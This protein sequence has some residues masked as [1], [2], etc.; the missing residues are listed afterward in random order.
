MERQKNTLAILTLVGS[1]LILLNIILIAMNGG[2]IMLSSSAQPID[3]L[4]SNSAPSWFRVALGIRDYAGGTALALGAVLAAVILYLAMSLYLSYRNAKISSLL[5]ILLSAVAL[6]YG[7]GFIIG[8]ALA[9]I[10]AALMY[11]APKKFNQT[12]MGK[13]LSSMRASS[14]VFQHFM[15]DS[16]VKDGA[17]VVLFANL[18]S[19]I[20]NGIYA[21][22]AT[23]IKTA[24][25][26]D[27]AF[28]ILLGGRLELDSSIVQTPI[29]LMGLGILKW[30][31]LSLILWLVGVNL[32]GQ[33]ASLASVA[34]LAGF[35]YA[36]VALQIFTPFV[37]A[38]SPYLA[39]WSLLVFLVTN[40]WLLLIL[41]VGMRHVMNVSL[42]KSAATVVSC[43]AIYTL[44]NYLILSQ[45][46]IPNF[47][48]YQFQSS[49]TMLFL[50]S[51][52]IA[53]PLLFMGK[54]TSG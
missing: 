16:S 33:K 47:I 49:N 6:L 54:K 9:F 53:V 34:A 36:P 10:G 37:F 32:F 1:I 28:Q 44:I 29:I 40:L 21:F 18:L 17:M 3:N 19:G 11:E 30:L 46:T 7:G 27:A 38:S 41:I 51:I 2:P 20:G 4:L 52:A 24:A 39:Q 45:V 50:T 31:I 14:Q 22:N 26:V 43:G 12:F 25:N 15:Q 13:M 8:S 42:T 48:T 23:T 35:A 5:I